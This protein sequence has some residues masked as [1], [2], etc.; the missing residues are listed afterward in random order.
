MRKHIACSCFILG[1]ISLMG[2][3][4][5]A[6]VK[7]HSLFTDNMVLQ[8]GVEIPIWGTADPGESVVVQLQEQKVSTEA[9][10]DGKWEMS[11]DPMEAGG[12][13]QLVFT[14]KNLI[15]LNNIM[16]GDVW[17]C[18]GQSNMQWPLRETENAEIEIA[19]SNFP[20]IRLTTVPR[21]VAGKPQDLLDCEWVE[22]SPD[23]SGN[24]SA[25]AYYF[26]RE[27]YQNLEV[28]IGLIHS[29]WGGSPAEAW[30]SLPTLKDNEKL[31]YM[32]DAWRK[33]LENFL[34]RLEEIEEEY[35]VWKEK[36][37]EAESQGKPVPAAPRIPNDP[38]RS[39][40]RPSGLFNTMIA[41]LTDFPIKGTIWYQGESNAKRAYEYRETFSTMIQDWREHWDIGNFP[42]L[43]V[44]LPNYES[45]D[46]VAWAELREAQ[47][48]ALTLPNTGMAI[49]IDLGDPN[50][51]HPRNK[52]E[53]G[54]RLALA[55]YGIAY[56]QDM[57][58]SGPIYD[59]MNI[60]GDQIRIRFK[61][62]GEG[63]IAKGD[64]MLTGFTIA[65]PD[66]EF[67]PAQAMIDRN[68]VVVSSAW[69]KN[70]I[71]VRY[72]WDDNPDCNLYNEAGLPASPFRTDDWEGV[73]AG[74][75]R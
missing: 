52:L 70:P 56:N 58:Y 28:P 21:R 51:I 30:T 8:R 71:A 41:P 74:V 54:E 32:L 13:Y 61:N 23:T 7:P 25:V 73:T 48:M 53:V 40:W 42:F 22:C 57:T 4:S 46:G 2:T 5:F 35:V 59:S 65:G 69:V 1:V 3:V 45:E 16:V 55:A 26:G 27:L 43:Y 19:Y 17:L 34:Q 14:G 67:R 33:D 11:L 38:R 62:V 47:T 39:H 10:E 36:A 12:P 9:S 15:A 49:T 50:D 64:D 20:D 18:S 75:K 6:A 72:G 24:F 68:T 60:E 37:A 31:N 66:K 29:S 63:L 44:Q